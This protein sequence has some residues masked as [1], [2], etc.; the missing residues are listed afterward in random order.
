M[1]TIRDKTVVDIIP[2]IHNND[3]KKVKDYNLV[4]FNQVILGILNQLQMERGT[5]TDFP[6]VGCLN[7][8]LSLFFAEDIGHIQ[9]NIRENL[10]YYQGYNINLEFF[11]EDVNSKEIN[12]SIS[13]DDVPNFRFSADLIKNKQSVKIVNPEILG[14]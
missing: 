3:V 5:M 7:D 10:Q 12:I 6:G 4:K 11:R 13:I 14:V 1:P 8:L 9:Y 2:D